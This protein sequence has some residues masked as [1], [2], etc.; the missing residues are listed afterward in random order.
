M[1]TVTIV[2]AWNGPGA[3]DA[4]LTVVRP[5][6]HGLHTHAD[7]GLG[8]RAFEHWYIDARLDSGHTV[9]GFLTKRRPEESTR[10]TPSIEIIVYAPDGS[11]R[12]VNASFPHD[13]CSFSRDDL[14]V[15]IGPNTAHIDRTGER[16][17]LHVHLA[18]EGVA[19]DLAFHCE[20]DAWMPGRGETHYGPSDHFGW[21]VAAP[22]ATV[23]GTL[24]LDGTVIDARGIG[25]S[26]HNWG[27]GDMRRIIERW[28]WGR[29]YLDDYSMLFAN[30]LT[31][32]RLGHHRS[33]P[34][35][36][37]RGSEIVLS[38]GEV[39]I[40]EGPMVFHPGADR[41]HPRWVQLE[42]PGH[43]T[44]RLDVDRVIDAQD[45]LAEV[46]V[47]RTRMLKPLIRLLVGRPGYFRFDSTFTLTVHEPDG[48]VTRTGRTL[49]EMV[50]LH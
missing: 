38:S 9:V 2:D 19:L 32:K 30:V 14:A 7:A 35:M 33:Q 31:Q 26:D 44:L 22:R 6:D 21:V 49:H 15:R 46:P 42:V 37:A 3:R 50:A 39:E 12:Q 47:V 43:V 41:E 40:T 1:S 48:V 20:I 16:P 36:L 18:A 23:T 5:A 25:Y 13:A 4:E 34:V 8:R 27:S 29:L 28:H 17:V 45:L 11:K 10:A 24:T